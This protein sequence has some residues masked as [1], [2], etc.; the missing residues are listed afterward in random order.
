M[1]ALVD[2][3]P[4]VNGMSAVVAVRSPRR[5]A[6]TLI[7]LLIVIAIIAILAAMLL[8]VLNS[9]KVRAQGIEC[10]SNLRQVM[11]GWEMYI[12]EN[13][14]LPLNCGTGDPGGD[15]P[16]KG[17][18]IPNWV[19]GNMTYGNADTV[20]W[21][22]MVNSRY[23]QLGPDVPNVKVY[24]CPADQSCENGPPG[25]GQPRVRSY[26]MS[27]AIGTI[28]LQ[29]SPRP[30]RALNQYASP[31]ITRNNPN[32]FWQTYW[33]PNQIIGAL[34]P[35]DLLV[36][37]DECPDTIN[38]GDWSESMALQPSQTYW[39][40]MPTKS[41]G[42]ACPFTFADGHAEMHRWM[43]S[44]AVRTVIYKYDGDTYTPSAGNPDIFWMCSHLTVPAFEGASMI[45]QK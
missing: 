37:A 40:D 2:K 32:G 33:K 18:T 15:S 34:G 6:F 42:D 36:L 30:E 41:H 23:S 3:T 31:P 13:V 20:N 22:M 38:D 45:P 7:E 27:C 4:G 21:Q 35:A 19:I 16:Q 44:G 26:S 10:M 29:G 1:N 25:D 39:G 24:R 9:A 5:R 14:F 12:S 17:N 43:R 28:N 8:P 11:T